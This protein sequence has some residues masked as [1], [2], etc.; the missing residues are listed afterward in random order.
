MPRTISSPYWFVRSSV[1]TPISP[2][3]PPLRLRAETFG[4]Y[5]SRSATSSTRRR[6]S[7][8][9]PG[10]PLITLDTVIAETPASSA[11]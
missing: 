11:T 9:A 6:V 8:E 7:S 5:P 2:L 3:R 1:M 4:R 10:L